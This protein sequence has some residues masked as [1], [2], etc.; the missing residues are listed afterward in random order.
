MSNINNYLKGSFE[1]LPVSHQLYFPTSTDP[2]AR[3]HK[4]VGK[5]YH[6]KYKL[7]YIQFHGLYKPITTHL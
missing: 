6:K 1:K 2:N 3:F 5:F 4:L 7:P